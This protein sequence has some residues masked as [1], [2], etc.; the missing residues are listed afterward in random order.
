MNDV[1]RTILRRLEWKE[2]AVFGAR[3][4]ATWHPRLFRVL[5]QSGVLAE[6]EPASTIECDGCEDACL[7]EVV[8]RTRG[9]TTYAFVPCAEHGRQP[10]SLDHLKR[11]TVD[12]EALTRRIAEALQ[13]LGD[14]GVEQV[15]AG[16]WWLG[17]RYVGRRRCSFFFS[18]PVVGSVS[19]Q[20][21]FDVHPQPVV[22]WPL[23]A[24]QSDAG[25]ATCFIALADFASLSESGIALDLPA[26]DDAVSPARRAE[27]PTVARFPTPKGARW[28]Q[29]VMRFV[30]ND[31]VKISLGNVTR[32]VNFAEMGFRDGRTG[33][34]IKLWN[35]LVLFATH[36]GEI[37][38]GDLPPRV[39]DKLKH[40]V[41]ELRKR[42]KAYFG[43]DGDPLYPYRT[44]GSYRTKFLIEDRRY[45]G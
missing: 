43:I 42:L 11:W 16:V 10:V 33:R 25:A 34:P 23:S 27:P 6:I 41:S 22:I 28:E 20:Y 12:E 38:W 26:L 9:E 4:V 1:W 40:N 37:A 44:E 21:S 2:R 30:S 36:T 24:P 31:D 17:S 35:T 13:P 14:G 19:G 15:A 3:E 7:K 29:V 18:R 32:E 8:I 39:H 5:L 45:G